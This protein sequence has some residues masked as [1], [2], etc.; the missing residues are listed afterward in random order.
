MT[1]IMAEKLEDLKERLAR[2]CRVLYI[3]GQSD[4]SIGHVSVRI[5]GENLF[6]MKAS[7]IGLEEVRTSDILTIDLDGK[8]VSGAGTLHKETPIHKE[9]YKTRQDVGSVVHTH[10]FHA[11]AFGCMEREFEAIDQYG[12]VF[13][14]GIPRFKFPGLISTPEQGRVLARSL[15]GGNCLL[16]VNHGIVTVGESVEEAALW[17]IWL[18]RA[19]KSQ[20]ALSAISHYHKVPKDLVPSLSTEVYSPRKAM[21]VWPYFARKEQSFFGSTK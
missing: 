16:L 1:T 11:V 5:P 3:E 14:E 20:M 17:A 2:A 4:G 8:K 15:G 18:E 9:I 19:S 21:L 10:P 7:G 12:L 6:L 13:S